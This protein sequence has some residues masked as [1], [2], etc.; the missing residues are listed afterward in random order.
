MTHLRAI[1]AAS[2][3]V[4]VLFLLLIATPEQAFAQ[5]QKFKIGGGAGFAWLSNPD[6]DHGSTAALGGF[7]GFRV[8]DNVSVETGFNFVRSNRV[9][10]ANGVPIDQAGSIPAFRFETN[11]YHLDGTFVYNIGR[12]QPFHPFVFAGGGLVRRDEKQTDF[13]FEPDPETGQDILVSQEVVLDGSEYE[14]TGHAGVGA[15]IYFMFNLAARVEYRMWFPRT[16]EKKTHQIFFAA[17]YFF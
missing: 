7:F 14:P 5:R 3:L 15:E 2:A 9:F 1:T 17:S 12:R 13:T 10:N 4:P 11:R 6:V 16:W 8:N